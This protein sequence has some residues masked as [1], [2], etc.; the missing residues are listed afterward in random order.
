[1]WTGIRRSAATAC[2]A[3][4]Q[5]SSTYRITSGIPNPSPTC[6]RPPKVSETA[7][8][9]VVHPVQQSP[10]AVQHA[11]HP[12]AGVRGA[13]HHRV[14][15]AVVPVVVADQRR[16]AR[17]DRRLRA[18]GEEGRRVPQRQ[19]R[20]RV[21][22]AGSA[23]PS[24]SAAAR[25]A[26]VRACAPRAGPGPGPRSDGRSRPPATTVRTP[27]R[28]LARWSRI[29]VAGF[30]FGEGPQGQRDFARRGRLLPRDGHRPGGPVGGGDP[31]Q[32]AAP[33]RPV[34]A[35]NPPLPVLP[36]GRRGHPARAVLVRVMRPPG[37]F[38]P[39][40]GPG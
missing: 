21:G 11:E 1:M 30:V 29:A 39:H 4:A 38:P 34:D 17:Q 40:P 35:L 27:A 18:P 31:G 33:V 37:R 7:Q 8:P 2:S 25:P 32:P 9:A 23:R 36:A 22:R 19:G 3:V 6:G 15:Q 5:V 24:R 14:E 28:S 10:Q 26:R 20:A 12:A 16:A 13:G